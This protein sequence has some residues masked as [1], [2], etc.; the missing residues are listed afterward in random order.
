MKKT[1]PTQWN[2]LPNL[3]PYNITGYFDGEG[4]FSVTI[5]KNPKMK[6][7]ISFTF[8][9]EMK[10]HSNS[11]H[12]LK[13]VQ[14]YFNNKGHIS[15]SNKHK[16]VMRFKISKLNDILN[17]V[18][19]HFDKYPL[20]TSKNLNYIDF[21]KVMFIIKSGEHLTEDGVK[22]IMD[23]TNQMN[24]K[25]SFKDKWEF[26]FNQAS[27]IK[28]NPEWVRTF[29]DGEGNFNFHIRKTSNS[30]SNNCTFSIFQ[31]V[32]DYHLMKLLIEFFGCGKLYPKTVTGSFESAENYYLDRK[33]KG[34]N[35]IIT[36]VVNTKNPN[37]DIIIPFFNKYSLFTAKS[38]DFEDWKKLINLS[39][40]KFYKTIEGRNV[41]LSISKS[42]NTGRVFETNN[43]ELDLVHSSLNPKVQD[44]S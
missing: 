5:Y 25:R 9:V 16:S 34:L 20:I 2:S 24:T 1:I 18:I 10:Q 42:M 33:K 15:F 12:I 38:L 14:Q 17:L 44:S 40:I 6:T 28:L 39:D 26:S 37:K 13:G 3:N 22:K 27:K 19:P 4:C 35:A 7:G 8:S 36:Y 11:A 31:N 23:I 29:T 32:H 30:N 43:L 21:K 41:M